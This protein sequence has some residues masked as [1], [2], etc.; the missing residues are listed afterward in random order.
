MPLPAAYVEDRADLGRRQQR[1]D[2]TTVNQSG[3]CAIS[4]AA[5]CDA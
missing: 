4:T 1:T 3:G 5:C 2:V